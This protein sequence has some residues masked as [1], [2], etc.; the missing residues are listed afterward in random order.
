MDS[1][2]GRK[3]TAIGGGEDF[4]QSLVDSALALQRFF[5]SSDC[6]TQLLEARF[7]DEASSFDWKDEDLAV[8]ALRSIAIPSCETCHTKI[9]VSRFAGKTELTPR[10]SYKG[11]IDQPSYLG[12]WRAV[13]VPVHTS[14]G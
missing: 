5:E 12:A 14:L 4:L 10:V 13:V 11:R 6:T 9:I 7:H 8:K 3:L 2:N 1:F